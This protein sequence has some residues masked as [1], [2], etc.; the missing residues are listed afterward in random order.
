MTLTLQIPA[1][2]EQRLRQRAKEQGKGL[3]QYAQEVLETD[4]KDVPAV[5]QGKRKPLAGRFEGL[6][7]QIPDLEE[8]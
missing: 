2:L 4:V 7:F 8:F 5:A 1:E 6:G 3:E